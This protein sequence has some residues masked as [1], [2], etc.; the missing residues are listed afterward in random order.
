M[1]FGI[2][3]AVINHKSSYSSMQASQEHEFLDE[4]SK[5]YDQPMQD[6]ES[7]FWNPI[8]NLDNR[9][10]SDDGGQGMQF[11]VQVS[12]HY[13]TLASSTATGG[14]PG[15][16]S[17]STVSFSANGSPIS[18]PDSQT[19]LSGTH[20]SPGNT[21]NSQV[22]GSYYINDVNNLKHKIRELETVMLGPE[23][24]ISISNEIAMF[25]GLGHYSSETGKLKRMME[26]ISSGD[27]K[28]VLVTCAKA[29]ADNDLLTAEWLMSELRPMVSVSGNPIQRLHAGRSC[30]QVI[31]FRKF[32]LQSLTLQ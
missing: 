30:C 26:M 18:P 15:N 29:V 14:Y 4:A 13:C 11:S 27:V 8:E 2:T 5:F 10:C 19:Y 12:E 17:P 24:D 20:H 6:F 3:L 7:Y 32:H 28:E 31:L 16:S 25:G 22:S 1:H 9:L 23:T 21:Y